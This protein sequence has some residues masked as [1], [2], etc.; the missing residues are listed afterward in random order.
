MHILFG[1]LIAFVASR[2]GT[3]VPRQLTNENFDILQRER[4][5]KLLQNL[6]P[7]YP[8]NGLPQAG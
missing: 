3:L 4:F 1:L 2:G 5:G 7:L 8:P 6:R